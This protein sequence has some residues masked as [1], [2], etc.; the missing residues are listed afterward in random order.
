MS[1]QPQATGLTVAG[2]C[3]PTIFR[4]S[5]TIGFN[6]WANSTLTDCR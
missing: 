2:C 1:V 6:V 4:P 5:A 3:Y